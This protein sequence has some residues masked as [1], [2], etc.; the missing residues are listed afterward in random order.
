MAKKK[1][2]SPKGAENNMRKLFDY[3]QNQNFESED[4]LK[5]FLNQT[6]GKTVGDIIPQNQHAPSKKEE[7]TDLVYEAYET[8][9][10]KGKKLV[11]KALRLD[12]NNVAA[13][14]YMGEVQNKIHQALPYF[15]KAMELARKELGEQTFE[16]AKGHFWGLS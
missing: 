1:P 15:Q 14:T 16:E 7:A 2:M 9:K 12:P 5:A 13:H 11:E 10:S 3:I 4:E 6:I 8:S